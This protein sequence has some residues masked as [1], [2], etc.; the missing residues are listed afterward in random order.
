MAR[1]L[2][3]N[4]RLGNG[5]MADRE[6]EHRSRSLGSPPGLR[7]RR[8]GPPGEGTLFPVVRC[9][10]AGC[11]P[12]P[13]A[14]LQG[15]THLSHDRRGCDR[16]GL[17]GHASPWR[18]SCGH[19]GRL[20]HVPAHGEASGSDGCLIPQI[21]SAFLF[22]GCLYLLR[23]ESLCLQKSHSSRRRQRLYRCG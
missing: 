6:A 21:S 8:P 20:K 12:D 4:A 17:A 1:L 15:N 23:G 19:H 13:P 16:S 9:G 18:K 5:S 3:G 14:V 2:Y 10:Y 7:F 22:D 11:D